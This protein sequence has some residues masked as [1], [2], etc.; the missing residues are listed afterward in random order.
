[1]LAIP[2]LP[3]REASSTY[4][5]DSGFVH[6]QLETWNVEAENENVPSRP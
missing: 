5:E 3:P 1:M 4:T 2:S 6:F